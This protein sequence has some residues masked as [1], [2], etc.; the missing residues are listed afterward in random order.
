MLSIDIATATRD[1]TEFTSL[2]AGKDHRCTVRAGTHVCLGN[3]P[4]GRP[5]S[6]S[7]WDCFRGWGDRKAPIPDHQIAQPSSTTTAI[8]VFHAMPKRGIY[9]RYFSSV[10][11]KFTPF[12]CV[13]HCESTNQHLT[14][15][16]CTRRVLENVESVARKAGQVRSTSLWLYD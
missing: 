1:F 9:Q 6:L 4:L 5:S 3:F 11:H 15:R 13:D 2:T 7:F 16:A 14:H 8:P 10:Q 12:C